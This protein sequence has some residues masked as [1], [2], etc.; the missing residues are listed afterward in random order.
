VGH[1]RRR[2][3]LEP[4]LPRL[5]GKRVKSIFVTN[6]SLSEQA[7][8]QNLRHWGSRLPM[9]VLCSGENGWFDDRTAGGDR[10]VV[11]RSAFVDDMN[12]F[13]STARATAV[14]PRKTH[15]DRWGRLVLQT[16]AGVRP[17]SG[18]TKMRILLRVIR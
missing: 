7:D 12:D 3:A 16:P 8:A 2:A 15:A 13:V 10:K 1:S 5:R 11:P 14:S 9:T 17:S 18:L 4:V 6:R